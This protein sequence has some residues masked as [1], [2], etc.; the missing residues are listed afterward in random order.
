[1]RTATRYALATAAVLGLAAFLATRTGERPRS[2]STPVARPIRVL[3]PDTVMDGPVETELRLGNYLLR[4]VIDTLE[5]GERVAEVFLRGRRVFSAYGATARFDSAG[6]DIT[7][8]G[9]PDVVV[10]VFSGGM[11]CCSQATVL[12]LGDTLQNFGVINGAHGEVELLD[13]DGDGVPEIRVGDWRFAYWRD[14]PFSESP[15]F[16]VI[17]R[18][19]GNGYRVACDLMRENP[20]SEAV[21]AA[22]ARETTRGWTRGDPPADFWAFAVQLIY[23]GNADLAWR[24]LDSSWPRSIP[25]KEQFLADLRAVLRNSPCWS[26]PPGRGPVS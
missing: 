11:H 19:Q 23:S 10:H 2:D 20:P 22:R 5:H 6:R 25:G 8:D 16:E 21:L 9:V 18:F 24:W 1:M 14:Y 13:V 26:P 3:P 4:V 17:L 7:G 12:G 15:Y